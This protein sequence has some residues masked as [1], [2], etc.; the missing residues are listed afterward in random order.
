MT[1]RPEHLNT[2]GSVAIRPVD[3]PVGECYDGSRDTGSA[4]TAGCVDDAECEPL[5]NAAWP[6]V[7]S[8]K[9]YRYHIAMVAARSAPAAATIAGTVALLPGLPGGAYDPVAH[10][11]A[12]CSGVAAGIPSRRDEDEPED[13]TQERT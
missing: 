7:G 3:D 9:L 1:V 13:Q 4:W 5:W 11:R 10:T 6:G 12:R 8:T 2:T